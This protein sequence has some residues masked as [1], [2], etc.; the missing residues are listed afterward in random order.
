MFL[1][2][3]PVTQDGA[4]GV[5]AGGVNCDDS[6]AQP[7]FAIVTGQLIHQRTFT[8]TW[9]PRE[10]QNPCAAAIWEYGLQQLGP[11]L[12]VVLHHADSTSQGPRVTGSQ[13]LNPRLVF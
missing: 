2:P 1:H 8:R 13:L 4:A 9:R 11:A 7:F 12:T 6:N 10:P 5:R 3:Y